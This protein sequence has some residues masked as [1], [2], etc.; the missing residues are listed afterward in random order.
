VVTVSKTRFSGLR[1]SEPARGF[2][3]IK[4]VTLNEGLPGPRCK[5]GSVVADNSSAIT[6]EDI[7]IQDGPVAVTLT[8]TVTGAPSHYRISASS[9]FTDASWQRYAT[10]IALPASV[11]QQ[12]QVFLQMR[13]F[14]GTSRGWIE[15]RS[16]IVTVRL[17][18]V[19]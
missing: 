2:D 9:E 8:P 7:D 11:S 3:L 13:R 17:T 12:E 4:Q 14:A 18:E 19:R 16:E 10:S 15:A 6:I 5:A 1:M